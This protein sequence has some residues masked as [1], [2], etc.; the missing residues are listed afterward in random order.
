MV[1][2]TR[3][4]SP[5]CTAWADKHLDRQ[6]FLAYQPL[7]TKRGNPAKSSIPNGCPLPLNASSAAEEH[8]LRLT[9]ADALES[10][11]FVKIAVAEED[12]ESQPLYR[13]V[14]YEGRRTEYILTPI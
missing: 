9:V 14:Q 12:G 1:Y 10:T 5:G 4:F 13:S 2:R 7:F 3:G 8:L 6:Y 11:G